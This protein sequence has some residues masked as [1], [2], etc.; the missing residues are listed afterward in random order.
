MKLCIFTNHFYPEDFKVN[1][2]AF[3]L[4]QREIDVTVITAIPDY[5]K[6]KFFEGYSLFKRRREVVN[7]VNVIRLPIIPRG[8]GG[9]IRLVLNYVSYFICIWFIRY[10]WCF[11]STTNH[12]HC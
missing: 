4:T 11:S 12:K 3:E 10:F 6:G 9:A 1:D 2:I 7:G 5:P 8:K